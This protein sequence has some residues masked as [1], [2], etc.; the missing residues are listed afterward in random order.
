MIVIN[1][2]ANSNKTGT[3]TN[4]DNVAAIYSFSKMYAVL[5]TDFVWGFV[6]GNLI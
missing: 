4:R 6:T 1:N 5:G 2:S 3:V